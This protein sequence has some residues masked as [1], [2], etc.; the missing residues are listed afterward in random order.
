[1][2]IIESLNY[3]IF[4]LKLVLKYVYGWKWILFLVGLG[5]LIRVDSCVVLLV[6]VNIC[7]YY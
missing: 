4:Y 5:R 3:I 2:E 1:M 6:V 7:F